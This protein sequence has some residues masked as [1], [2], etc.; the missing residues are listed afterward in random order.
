MLLNAVTTTGASDAIKGKYV[1]SAQAS[2]QTTAGSGAAT[3][4]IEV[5]NDKVNWLVAFTISLTLGTATTSDGQHLI[6]RWEWVRA[7][8]TSLTGTGASVSVTA[9]DGATV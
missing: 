1:H 2:G 7:N 8:V 9:G 6:A 4:N 5:S 3:I